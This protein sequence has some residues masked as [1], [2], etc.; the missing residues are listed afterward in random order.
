M[1]AQYRKAGESRSQPPRGGEGE[2]PRPANRQLNG[3]CSL[4]QPTARKGPQPAR[5]RAYP[6]EEGVRCRSQGTRPA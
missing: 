2:R 5:E 3:R 6:F 4:I 1:V